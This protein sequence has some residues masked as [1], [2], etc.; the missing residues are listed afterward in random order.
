MQAA[1][2]AAGSAAT[3]KP[4]SDDGREKKKEEGRDAIK[5]QKT[6]PKHFC[7]PRFML[8]DFKLWGWA[9]YFVVLHLDETRAAHGSSRIGDA[10]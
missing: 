7:S 9:W 2:A 5:S 10:R 4:G 6:K 3:C 1:A 8:I